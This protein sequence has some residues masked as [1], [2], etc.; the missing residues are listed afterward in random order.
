M[1]TAII[2][3]ALACHATLTAPATGHPLSRR[4]VIDHDAVVGFPE[5]VPSGITGELYL[6]YQPRLK[7][8][9]GCVP[10]PAVNEAG[11]TR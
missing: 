3:E 1:R 9:S 5:A 4:A 8:F 11:D 10:F 7:V 6:K 2:F